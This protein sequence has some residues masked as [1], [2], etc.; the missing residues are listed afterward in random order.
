MA[1]TAPT[2]TSIGNYLTSLGY[3]ASKVEQVVITPSTFTVWYRVVNP[4]D[5]TRYTL[6]EDGYY[7]Q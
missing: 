4:T 3:D 2:K 6:Q 5:P 1:T 7:L